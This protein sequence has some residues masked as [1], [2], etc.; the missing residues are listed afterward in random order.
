M[1]DPR[2]VSFT[3]LSKNFPKVEKLVYPSALAISVKD[4]PLQHAEDVDTERVERAYKVAVLM[5][6]LSRAPTTQQVMVLGVTDLME[7]YN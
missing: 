2:F 6:E 7:K 4:S 5:P 3:G 1:F